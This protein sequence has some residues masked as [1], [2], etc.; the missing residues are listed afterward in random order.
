MCPGRSISRRFVD[1]R[2]EA[3]GA[4]PRIGENERGTRFFHVNYYIV[5]Y[6]A[7]SAGAYVRFCEACFCEASFREASF[8]EAS[9]RE[10]GFG[11]KTRAVVPG[12]QAGHRRCGPENRKRI[13]LFRRRGD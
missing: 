2:G 12:L 3:L 13:F 1:H 9:F 8:R 11:R 5:D 10:T 4:S 7:V 6:G